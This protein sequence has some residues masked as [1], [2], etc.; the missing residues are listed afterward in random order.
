MTRRLVSIAAS[1]LLAGCG[2]SLTAL[3]TEAMDGCIAERNGD[4]TS[5]NGV[6]ALDKPLPPALTTLA[7]KLAYDRA[8][9]QFATIAQVARDQVTLVCALES[10]SAYRHGDAGVLLAKYTRHPDAAVA[11]NAKRLLAS[12]Q[13]PLPPGL[14]P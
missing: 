4:F 2:K 13:D 5:G 10:A 9:K 12:T 1:V 11:E 7:Q 3:T 6:N 14:A 8:F